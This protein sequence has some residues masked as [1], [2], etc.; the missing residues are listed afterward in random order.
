[1]QAE[2]AHPGSLGCH[3]VRVGKD[4]PRRV[5]SFARS[6]S[7]DAGRL[8]GEEGLIRNGHYFTIPKSQSNR[9][10][11]RTTLGFSSPSW[12][13]A[14]EARKEEGSHYRSYTVGE[15]FSDDQR[16]GQCWKYPRHFHLPHTPF[17]DAC[18][19]RNF[20]SSFSGNR[21]VGLD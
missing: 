21:S 4:P 17:L 16:R 7:I 20:S 15:S 11:L 5:P 19:V 14:A 9:I 2:W 10:W 8:S 13:G 18:G 3:P 6:K 12:P 1:M